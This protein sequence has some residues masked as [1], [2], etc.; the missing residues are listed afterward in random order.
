MRT[1]TWLVAGVAFVCSCATSRGAEVA[2]A[3]S[4]DLANLRVAIHA[5]DEGV[6]D[7]SNYHRYSAISVGVAVAALLRQ[8]GY[9]IV[10]NA[11]ENAE[12]VLRVH[13]S[14]R[15][16][17]NA[18]RFI[19]VSVG[20]QSPSPSRTLLITT[21]VATRPGNAAVVDQASISFPAHTGALA[22]DEF[23]PLERDFRATGKLSAYAAAILRE[24]RAAAEQAALEAR[25][26]AERAR[27]E[28]QERASSRN[29]ADDAAWTEATTPSAV[30]SCQ[31][32]KQS[33]DCAEVRAYLARFG[34]QGR[35]GNDA[36]TILTGAEPLLARLADEEQWADVDLSKCKRPTTSTDCAPIDAYLRD[37]PQ[38]AHV[39]E[40]LKLLGAARSKVSSLVKTEEAKARQEEQA[41]QREEAE[42]PRRALR[43]RY[44][45]AKSR[46]ISAGG[47]KFVTPAERGFRNVSDAL[48]KRIRLDAKFR[49]E[50]P[51]QECQ[52][53]SKLQ[54][55][56]VTFDQLA[57]AQR[58]AMQVLEQVGI[59]SV[60]AGCGEAFNDFYVVGLEC[61]EPDEDGG[62]SACK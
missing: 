7:P 10:S 34:E 16:E 18:F 51:E 55:Y 13:L 61:F 46:L 23:A 28:E 2:P 58:S 14:S 17:H 4:A 44:E 26:Q 40:A 41:R 22:A 27:I 52:S 56:A 57:G 45:D 25:E 3:L 48:R 60:Y 33:K 42:A 8:A 36:K 47:K 30:A 32:P 53:R 39:N 35:H 5:D 20:G 21:V 6:V 12:L 15:E 1:G 62:P 9:H 49:D 31:S 37:R 24:R 50:C 19:N 29:N 11:D 54:T 38:G 43:E 59:G